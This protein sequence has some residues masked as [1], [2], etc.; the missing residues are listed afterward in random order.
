MAAHG[1]CRSWLP[2]GTT[3]LRPFSGLLLWDR[4]LSSEGKLRCKRGVIRLA[5]S[6]PDG[7]TIPWSSN[8]QDAGVWFRR[9]EFKS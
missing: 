3:F 9:S 8:W 5:G 1:D 7:P 2:P 6:T 4:G